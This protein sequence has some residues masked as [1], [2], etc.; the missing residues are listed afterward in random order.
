MPA[1]L[2]IKGHIRTVDDARP[3]ARSL[4][5]AD[6][7]IVAIG[8]EPDDTDAWVGPDTTVLDIGDGCVLPGFVEAH[9]HPLMEAVALSDRMVDIRPVT[10]RSADDVVAAVHAE[11]VAG[12]DRDTPDPS[13][14]R[15]GRNADGE[16]D[17]TAEES[18]AVFPLLGGAIKVS[19]YPAMLMAECARLNRAGLTTC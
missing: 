1:D 9:G 2:V 13:G 18:A 5:V 8:M 19:D 17:G 6:G 7:R 11:V 15:Y 10:L 14:A 12:L 4:A 16:L 3:T